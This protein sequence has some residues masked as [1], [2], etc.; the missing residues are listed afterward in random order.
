MKKKILRTASGLLFGLACG[1]TIMLSSV[2]W[3]SQVAAEQRAETLRS[4]SL[5]ENHPERLRVASTGDIKI[6]EPIPEEVAEEPEYDLIPMGTYRLSFY[7]PCK[8]CCGKSDGITA[9]GT[10]ATQGRTVASGKEFPFGSVLVIDGHEYVVE[11]RG[12]GNGKLDI[13]MD[14]HQECLRNGIQYKDVFM[15]VER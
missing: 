3:A 13:F 15:R 14:D 8:R 5:F 1:T 7:C 10:H 4:I 11:D 12:V 2:A 9:S 6:V